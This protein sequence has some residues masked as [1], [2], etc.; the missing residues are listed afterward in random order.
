[1]I[2][3][4]SKIIKEMKEISPEIKICCQL[5]H[6]GP[7][8]GAPNKIVLNEAT[9]ED[10]ETIVEQFKAA[11]IRAKQ[12]GY[13]CVQIHSAHCYLLS[14]SIS[15][16]YNKR[17][18]SWAAKD[19]KLLKMVFDAVK[20]TDQV[21]GVKLQCDDFAEAGMNKQQACKIL[22]EIQFDFVEI[23]GGGLGGPGHAYGT[24]RPGK[25]NYYYKHV[26]EAFKEA[27]LLQK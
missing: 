18:D 8:G 19:F 11:A 24:I 15:G 27:G 25:D 1:M 2:Q 14:Q 13:D 21:V 6:A 9:D 4:H 3:Y 5:A 10:F 17:A 7:H 20:S 23:S 26:M 16:L 12:A 22:E